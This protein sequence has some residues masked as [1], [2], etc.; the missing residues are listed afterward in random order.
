[1][2]SDLWKISLFVQ[3]ST[4]FLSA[5]R[6]KEKQKGKKLPQSLAVSVDKTITPT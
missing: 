6:K 2:V 3:R 1:M 5:K 4:F